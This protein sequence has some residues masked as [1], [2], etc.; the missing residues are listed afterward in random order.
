MRDHRGSLLLYSIP[1]PDIQS[2]KGKMS[3]KDVEEM[4]CIAFVLERIRSI[5]R[6]ISEM[7]AYQTQP[8]TNHCLIFAKSFIK[9]LLVSGCFYYT[10]LLR[11]F[12]KK[13]KMFT[14]FF[15]K[16]DYTLRES[17]CF[18]QSNSTLDI[19]MKSTVLPCFKAKNILI[20]AC[21]SGIVAASNS[22]WRLI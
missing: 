17:H 11:R 22:S 13:T 19:G 12:F 16:E 21:S 7:T 5:A 4:T 9:R 20:M 18:V 2:P 3:K 1:A 10:T 14:N 8:P 15:E 6:N